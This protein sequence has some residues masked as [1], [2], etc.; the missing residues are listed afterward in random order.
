MGDRVPLQTGSALTLATNSGYAICT[1]TCTITVPVP[2]AG[3][4][5]CVLNGDNVSTVITLSALGGS[6]QYENTA[7]T[8]FGT[9]GTGTL[10]SGGAVGDMICIVGQDATHFLSATFKG[11]W[12]AS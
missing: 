12:T 3:N 2:A 10:V 4:Q 5:F 11:T 7:R 6:A 9:A 8:S 1:T